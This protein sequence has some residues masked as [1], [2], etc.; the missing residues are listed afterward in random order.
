[1]PSIHDNPKDAAQAYI[2]HLETA[3]YK[4]YEN[5]V[6]SNY[7]FWLCCH[8]LALV[9]G[10]GTSVLAALLKQKLLSGESV[11]WVVVIVP[12]VGSVA[13]TVMVQS[14][15]Y[16]RWR[17]REAGRIGFQT[18][19][20][21]GRRRFAAATTPAEFSELHKDLSDETA[22][23]EKEQSKSFFAITPSRPK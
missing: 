3:Y 21:E 4:W 18:L 14:R 5:D 19:V 23:I 2:V 16:D 10:F 13:S 11:A 12:F 20:T 6:K 17:L 1:M 15:V 9:A 8:V 22:K 7:R